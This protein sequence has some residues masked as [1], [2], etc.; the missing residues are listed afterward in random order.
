MSMKDNGWKYHRD[1]EGV[2]AASERTLRRLQRLPAPE[3]RSEYKFPLLV[4]PSG[5]RLEFASGAYALLIALFQ[6]LLN[7]DPSF[8][9]DHLQEQAEKFVKFGESFFKKTQGG[10]LWKGMSKLWRKP[11]LVFRECKR[12]RT[13]RGWGSSNARFTLTPIGVRDAWFLCLH[14]EEHSGMFERFHGGRR[15]KGHSRTHPSLTRASTRLALTSES[16]HLREGG[17]AGMRHTPAGSAGTREPGDGEGDCDDD[18]MGI[19]HAS[20]WQRAAGSSSSFTRTSHSPGVSSGQTAQ[21]LAAQAAKARLKE[22]Q[23]AAASTAKQLLASATPTHSSSSG[24]TPAGAGN[25]VAGAKRPRAAAGYELH[26]AHASKKAVTDTGAFA[27]DGEV[28]IIDSDSEEDDDTDDE[29]EDVSASQSSFQHS[30]Q[31]AVPSFPKFPFDWDS[32]YGDYEI[33]QLDDAYG[34]IV[35]LRSQYDYA[36]SPDGEIDLETLVKKVVPDVLGY[37]VMQAPPTY[38]LLTVPALVTSMLGGL[39]PC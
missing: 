14:H 24:S 3:H 39:G 23:A 5:K 28:L 30:S 35:Q 15:Y 10:D 22:S 29:I 13:T 34:T 1:S 8:S 36:T 38:H 25:G 26:D 31:S 6:G 16:S 18:G 20:N 32:F 2:A 7:G 12:Y 33:T 4:C 17:Q 37:A 9:I 27:T 19:A 21:Q 11:G